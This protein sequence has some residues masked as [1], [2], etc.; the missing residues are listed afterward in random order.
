LYVEITMP[1][2]GVTRLSQEGHSLLVYGMQ[3]RPLVCARARP[4]D[5]AQVALR[6]YG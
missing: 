1:S 2:Q 5:L 3:A 4:T 6:I